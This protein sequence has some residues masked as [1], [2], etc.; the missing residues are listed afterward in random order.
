MKQHG[1]F[2]TIEATREAYSPEDLRR[3]MTVGEMIE[4]LQQFD[5]ETPVAISH[6]SGYIYGAITTYNFNE[7]ELEEED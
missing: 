2:I 3:T 6:D 7:L 1:F 4:Y 5:E